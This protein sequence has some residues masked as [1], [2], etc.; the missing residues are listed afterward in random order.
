MESTWAHIAQKEG[1]FVVWSADAR[2][3]AYIIVF[4]TPEYRARFTEALWMEAQLI[5]E[6]HQ[7]GVYVY[8]FDSETM[9][10]S[11]I[12]ANLT[13]RVP[14]MGSFEEWWDFC[15]RE[16]RALS[17]AVATAD[18]KARSLNTQ[19]RAVPRR[20]SRL[21]TLAPSR[22]RALNFAPWCPRAFT[23]ARPHTLASSTSCWRNLTPS[24]SV[25]RQHSGFNE[26]EAPPKRCRSRGWWR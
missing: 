14:M 2:L 22:P 7:S 11:D 10:A 12:R 26:H 25:P 8:I 21:H 18:E 3:A 19:Y 13:D 23:P 15:T 1:W 5:Y 9:T 16:S 4:F 24:H 17:S 6:L 20:S